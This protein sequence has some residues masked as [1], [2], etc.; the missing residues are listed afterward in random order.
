MAESHPLLRRLPGFSTVGDRPTAP[1]ADS[2][3]DAFLDYASELNLELYPAQEEAIVELLAGNHVILDTPTGSGKSLVAL[4]AQFG[5]LAR[6]QRSFYT[7]PIK[8]LVSE[9]F[10][11]LCRD[12]GTDNVGMLTGDAAVNPDAPVICCTAEI[13]ANLALRDGASAPVDVV[14]MDEFHFFAEPTR[15]WAWQVPLVELPR[16]QFLLMSA[17]LGPVN[18]FQTE[19]RR[20]TG[21]E[22]VL[23][24][25]TDRPVPLEYTYRE[26]PLH[27]SLLELAERAM[28][29]AYLVNFTQNSA[30]ERAQAL[31]SL[32]L[33]TRDDKD[34]IGA[35]VAGFRFDTPFGADLKRYLGHGIGV[36]H[37]GMLPKYRL[38]VEKLAQEGLLKVISGTD[39]LGV[40]INVP[41]RTVLFS[42]LCKYDGR[43]TRVLNVREFKQ[44]AG[45][46]GRKGY[47]DVGY[48]WA[49][50]PEH[51]IENLR[52]DQ[53]VSD[54]R[55]KKRP[56]RKPPEFGYA[57]WNAEIFER[58]AASPPEQLQ[59]SFDVSHAM[60]LNLLDRPGDGCAAVRTLLSELNEP[61]PSY[62]RLVRR[63][64]SMYRSLLSQ[65]ILER[66]DTPDESGR[67]VRIDLALQDDFRLNQPLSPW[68]LHAVGALDP[69]S[70]DHAADVLSVV[71]A[72]LDDPR[73]VLARQLERARDQAMA[74]A[75]AEGKDY[76]ERQ[77]VL[78]EVTHPQPNAES[79]YESFNAWRG[80]HPWVEETIHPK[81]VTRE[82]FERGLTVREY[83]RIYGLKRSEGVLLRY[84]SDTYKALVQTVPM[85]LATDELDE[86]IDWL[87][88]NVRNVDSSLID[89]WERLA[90]PEALEGPDPLPP[91][92]S[93]ITTNRRAFRVMVRNQV[94]SWVRQLA[95]RD[96]RDLPELS[97]GW[98]A[99]LEAYWEQYDEIRVDAEARGAAYFHLDEAPEAWTVRQTLLDPE[100]HG[101]WHLRARV[102]L[103]ASRAEDRP[104]ITVDALGRFGEVP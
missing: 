17:T 53:A 27:E 18:R 35:A 5:A 71:E 50:A 60:L 92:P 78:A 88:A 91:P 52:A 77:A 75:R 41:I 65:G 66:L 99:A 32:Q 42:Q 93:D 82:L 72:V 14:V 44:I 101:D 70:P 96:H 97:G 38:L 85:D 61:R 80:R 58:L 89:E 102:D 73:P 103:V 47:D 83:I 13:L 81:A 12:L 33:T 68:I 45:R 19:L 51:V 94:F 7:A 55:K 98:S 24:R 62:R 31:T 104:V 64:I 100:G 2:I 39:T 16:A 20:R 56:K 22:C 63:S 6:G 30:V 25:N 95:R 67:T 90:N 23:V 40:G 8:A 11:A 15:G 26:T 59:S 43:T 21:R 87:G 10:F 86:L 54:G 84:L 36:H 69:A 57:P 28:L 3:L 46:A 76:D 4:A 48:V 1:D 74:A 37:A 34:A 49:Q 79:L 9:K 29:P